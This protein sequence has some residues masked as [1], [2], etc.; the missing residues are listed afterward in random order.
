MP[1]K[2]LNGREAEMIA[3]H[4]LTHRDEI[5][6]YMHQKRWLELACLADYIAADV[7]PALAH[8][9]TALYR[10]LRKAITEVTVMGYGSLSAA[11]LRALAAKAAATAA[12][13]SA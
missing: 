3:I 9:D 4:L 5:G 10:T 7:P 8:T 11:N 13:I 1:P 6:V 2:S 12:R